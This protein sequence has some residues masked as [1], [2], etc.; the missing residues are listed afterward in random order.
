M[1]WKYSLVWIVEQRT[2]FLAPHR[3]VCPVV[4]PRVRAHPRPAVVVL[5]D[6]SGM[7][8]VNDLDERRSRPR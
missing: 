2:N 6:R 4:R 3:L 1:R 7:G 8:R 5:G